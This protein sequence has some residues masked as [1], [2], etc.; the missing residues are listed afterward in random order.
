[1][2]VVCARAELEALLRIT[3]E[4]AVDGLPLELQRNGK[5]S[6]SDY[7]DYQVE[8]YN[9]PGAEIWAKW[10]RLQQQQLAGE[11][12]GLGSLRP[13]STDFP[14]VTAVE[15]STRRLQPR[16]PPS[17]FEQLR[18]L[19]ASYAVQQRRLAAGSGALAEWAALV[20]V[21]A[22]VGVLQRSQ[23][24][25]GYEKLPTIYVLTLTLFSLFVALP[26]VRTFAFDTQSFWREA[27]A[28]VSPTAFYVSRALADLPGLAMRALV[29]ALVFWSCAFW[30][31]PFG[32]LLLLL[33]DVMLCASGLAY[34]IAITVPPSLAVTVCGVLICSLCG[35][36]AGIVPTY[37]EAGPLMKLMLELSYGRWA[38]Q[39]LASA[40][41][42]NIPNAL[43]A[44]QGRQLIAMFAWPS[45]EELASLG[46]G[47]CTQPLGVLLALGLALRVLGCVAINYANG[48]QFGRPPFCAPAPRVALRPGSRRPNA[49]GGG[50]RPRISRKP[51]LLGQH[52]VMSSSML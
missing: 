3:D 20:V 26:A 15:A 48:S 45:A 38:T 31:G 22:F 9:L 14:A 8:V 4:N 16:E 34:V 40:D 35:F 11:T 19:I 39:C 52:R 42:S 50:G 49:K 36:F 33:L 32:T 10:S 21:G 44:E 17:F 12:A 24:P 25:D 23:L 28:G 27:S 2:G 29:F 51:L 6:A 13:H 37:A 47:P 46:R 7:Y 30:N 41:F 43:Y 18:T 5:L 1:M